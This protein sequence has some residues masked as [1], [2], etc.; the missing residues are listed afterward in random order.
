VVSVRADRETL[1][2]RRRR[3]ALGEIGHELAIERA[4]LYTTVGWA[5]DPATLLL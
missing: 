5:I 3:L 1:D 2:T 4:L